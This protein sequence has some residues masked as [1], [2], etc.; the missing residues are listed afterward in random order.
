V[1]P[2][3][4]G[5]VAS[6]APETFRRRDRMFRRSGHRLGAG[7]G[8]VTAWSGELR[9]SSPARSC[10]MTAWSGE[11]GTGSPPRSCGMNCH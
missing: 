9:T 10:G 3:W 2:H 6:A 1:Q 11:V 4:S 8:G 5:E 7:P